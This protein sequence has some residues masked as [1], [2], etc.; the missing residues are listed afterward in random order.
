MTAVFPQRRVPC[1][2]LSSV[3]ALP[4]G[5]PIITTAA[6]ALSPPAPSPQLPSDLK[7]NCRASPTPRAVGKP[8][9]DGEGQPDCVRPSQPH[10][11]GA[12]I[13]IVQM[14]KQSP[15]GKITAD[16]SFA[17]ALLCILWREG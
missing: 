5:R 1:S 8:S 12:L 16:L 10:D 17:G 14:G 13:P 7:S 4:H 9:C 3:D 11:V 15:S 6:P 2:V